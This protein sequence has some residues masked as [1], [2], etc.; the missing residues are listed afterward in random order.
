VGESLVVVAEIPDGHPQAVGA[1]WLRHIKIS[2]VQIENFPLT[3]Y[4]GEYRH[5]Y[6]IPE[7]SRSGVVG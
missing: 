7:G 3:L 2:Q 1:A 4:K 5:P 6:S